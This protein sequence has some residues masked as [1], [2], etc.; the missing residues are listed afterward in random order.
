[1]DGEGLWS[2]HLHPGTSDGKRRRSIEGHNSDHFAI[3]REGRDFCRQNIVQAFNESWYVLHHGLPDHVEIGFE[4][5]RGS[6][7]GEY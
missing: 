5:M 4:S 6:G 7:D 2:N 1:M 3:L